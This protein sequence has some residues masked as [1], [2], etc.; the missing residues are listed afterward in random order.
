MW[1]PAICTVN[2]PSMQLSMELTSAGTARSQL[3]AHTQLTQNTSDAPVQVLVRDPVAVVNSF[4]EVLEATLEDTCYPALCTI[5]SE[6]RNNGCELCL[7]S[8]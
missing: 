7:A 8:Q 2:H 1:S 4:T 6:L 3:E 5:I